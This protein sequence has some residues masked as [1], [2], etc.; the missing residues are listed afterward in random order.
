MDMSYFE[1]TDYKA[2]LVGMTDLV[3]PAAVIDRS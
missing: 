1:S 2:W 3:H